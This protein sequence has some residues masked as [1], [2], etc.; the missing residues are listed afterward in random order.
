MCTQPCSTR[1]QDVGLVQP[2]AMLL[3]RVGVAGPALW[4]DH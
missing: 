4:G 1:T 3:S 2:E